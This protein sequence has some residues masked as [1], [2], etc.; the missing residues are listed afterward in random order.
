MEQRVATAGTLEAV[1][2]TIPVVLHADFSEIDLGTWP[3][4]VHAML[5]AEPAMSRASTKTVLVN[6]AVFFA[7]SEPHQRGILAHEIAHALRAWAGIKVG[8]TEEEI[9]ADLLACRMGFAEELINERRQRDP[10][11]ADALLLWQDHAAARATSFQWY[12]QALLRSLI[13]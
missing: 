5:R 3:P 11:R 2:A 12:Q 7:L 10:G 4:R 13:G 1:G 6:D 9:E 8:T